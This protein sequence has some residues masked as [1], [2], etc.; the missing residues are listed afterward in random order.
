MQ[1]ELDARIVRAL[2]AEAEAFPLTVLPEQIE[3]RLS[4]SVGL[5]WLTPAAVALGLVALVLAVSFGV[6][7]P[8]FAGVGDAPL[9]N[10][11]LQ[12]WPDRPLPA[13]YDW[14]GIREAL[15]PRGLLLE[16]PSEAESAR[17]SVEIDDLLTAVEQHLAD[18]PRATVVSVHMAVVTREPLERGQLM[19]REPVFVVET[20]GYATGNCFDL[21]SATGE[22]SI[23]GACFYSNRSMPR[24]ATSATASPGNVGESCAV[25]RP[26]PPFAAPSPYPASP[27]NEHS[28]WFG[29][30][31]LWTMLELD[32]EVWDAANTSFPVQIKTF[33]WS[34]DWPGQRIEQE[35][36]ITV[37]ATRLD[38]PGTITTDDATNA[39]ADSL[40]GEAMLV[41]IEFP[42]PGCWQLAAEYR[43]AVLSY[44]VWITD[45]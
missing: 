20:T 17:V 38:G 28:A 41:G 8:K 16:Y 14:A 26:D 33:W 1:D 30:P 3:G 39:A 25:T 6:A 18:E 45:E 7:S 37:V 21:W 27:P 35:P 22:G 44:V 40:G 23:L 42:T 11:H 15:R 24:P 29:T 10:Q 5:T 2:R 12:L 4:R 36:A 43:G 32:G 31:Q 9:E 19:K 13:P 34:S